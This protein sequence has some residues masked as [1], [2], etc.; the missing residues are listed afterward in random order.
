VAGR[1]AAQLSGW[2]DLLLA[3]FLTVGT[4]A[5]LGWAQQLY[6]LPIA[7]FGLSVAA[8]ELPELARLQSGG[9]TDAVRRRLGAALGRSVYLVAPTV[10]G[11]LA[12][13]FLVVGL[14]YRSG[15]FGPAD[16]WLVY[17]TLCGYTCGL[18]AT[19]S[20][21][22]LQNAFFA[23]GD[24][25]TPARV[26]VARL[27]VSAVLGAATCFPLDRVRLAAIVDA[28]GAE[29]LSLAPLGLALASAVAAWLELWLLRRRLPAEVRHRGAWRRAV[30]PV[31]G[32]LAA[33]AVGAAAWWSLRG[34]AP[35][36]QSAAVLPVFAAAYL[37][38]TWRRLRAE[39]LGPGQE[40]TP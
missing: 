22:L 3:S 24:T 13:G 28:T 32:A 16:N 29:R 10:V 30:G 26:A 4:L 2:I 34:A 18:P 20:S 14:V 17:L 37:T 12:L 1:G 38:M 15:H 25:R 21:R 8:V 6:L 27:G 36:W 5:A 31:A 23:A 11:F 39:L 19:I 40:T 33:A 35:W 9:Q 7:L